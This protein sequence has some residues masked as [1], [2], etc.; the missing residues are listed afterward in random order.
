MAQVPTIW[1]HTCMPAAP[2]T[3]RA[4]G[5]ETVVPDSPAGTQSIRR[6]IGALRQI[7]TYDRGGIRLV[8]LMRNLKLERSTAHRILRCLVAEN[9]VV[10]KQPGRR[11]VLGPLAFELGLGAARRFRLA[12]VCRP[13][14]QRLAERTEDVVFVS[15]ASGLDLVCVDR[16]EGRYPIKAYTLDVGA[17]RPLGFGAAGG[18][19]LSLFPD[20]EIRDVLRRNALA[21]RAYSNVTVEAGLRRVLLAKARGYA[22]NTRPT[23]GLKAV[24]VPFRDGQGQPLGAVSLC[25]ISSRMRD[26]R[27]RELVDLIRGEVAVIEAQ[28]RTETTPPADAG[29]L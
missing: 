11:Y 6:A 12:D 13:S 15:V 21:L 8:D 10:Q 9:I 26:K 1:E 22:L 3:A 7:A 24:A 18:A 16:V 25:A 5:P 14:L 19:I 27:V 29:G 2:S 23:M 4:R 20:R 28:L 17:R